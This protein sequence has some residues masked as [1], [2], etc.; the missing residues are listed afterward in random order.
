V[1]QPAQHA[2]P[3]PHPTRLER[4]QPDLGVGTRRTRLYRGAVSDDGLA[5]SLWEHMRALA[6]LYERGVTQ[7]DEAALFRMIKQMRQIAS[8]ASKTTK[9]MRRA[10]QR[11]AL[12]P[13]SAGLLGSRVRSRHHLARS[14]Q[15]QRP[16]DSIRLN[17]GDDDRRRSPELVSPVPHSASGGWL[18]AGERASISVRTGSATRERSRPSPGWRPCWGGPISRGCRI[19]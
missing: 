6:R 2:R 7:V 3:V 14:L 10:A 17:S 19:C 9:R 1:D 4:H 8:T 11:R 12:S 13:Q 15:N 16:F 5:V 18:P